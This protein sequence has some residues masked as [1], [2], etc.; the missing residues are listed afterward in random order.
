MTQPNLP[1]ALALPVLSVQWLIIQVYLSTDL[2]TFC[3]HVCSE[4]YL[5]QHQ[6]DHELEP[7]PDFS[8]D[9]SSKIHQCQVP[10]CFKRF[11]SLSSLSQHKQVFYALVLFPSFLISTKHIQLFKQFLVVIANSQC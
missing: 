8:G 10:G 9:G 4:P 1:L 11:Q 3:E 6:D 2:A 5:L 7:E